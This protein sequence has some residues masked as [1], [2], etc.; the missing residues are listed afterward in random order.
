MCAVAGPAARHS[1]KVDR[2]LENVC[3]VPE[4]AGRPD[5]GNE[6]PQAARR[7]RGRRTASLAAC[8]LTA[9]PAADPRLFPEA[10]DLGHPDT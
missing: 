4:L 5:N 2:G 9:L 8:W 3:Q 10:A 6:G 7:S 1:W